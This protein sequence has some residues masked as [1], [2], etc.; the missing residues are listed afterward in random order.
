MSHTGENGEL[1]L[2]KADAPLQAGEQALSVSS[3][4]LV[5]LLES[6]LSKVTIGPVGREYA[7]T[8]LMKLSTRLPDHSEYIQV[9]LHNM[10][11]AAARPDCCLMTSYGLLSLHQENGRCTAG[12]VM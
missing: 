12:G 7:L 2:G 4:E 11:T 5:S 8:A 10:L 1:L 3:Q 9:S 6:V